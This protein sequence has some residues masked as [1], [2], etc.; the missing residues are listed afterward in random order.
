MIKKI[1]LQNFRNLPG[2]VFEFSDKTT[3]IIGPNAAGKT[4]L[5]ESIYMLSAGK[6]FKASIESEVRKKCTYLC[7]SNFAPALTLTIVS[8]SPSQAKGCTTAPLNRIRRR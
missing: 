5:L 3:V 7:V 6:S 1:R 4:N 2:E 8:G